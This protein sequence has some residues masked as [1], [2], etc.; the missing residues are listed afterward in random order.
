MTLFQLSHS[1]RGPECYGFNRV[2]KREELL[3]ACVAPSKALAPQMQ[4]Q[5]DKKEGNLWTLAVW[6]INLPI[7]LSG[8]AAIGSCLKLP[9]LGVHHVS[10][11]YAPSNLQ[12]LAINRSFFCREIW[13]CISGGSVASTLTE[14]LSTYCSEIAAQMVSL[15]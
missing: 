14:V 4:L 15:K 13:I 3:T 10:S 7:G 2:P 9:V 8:Q 12:H 5:W 11:Q 1:Q 6:K